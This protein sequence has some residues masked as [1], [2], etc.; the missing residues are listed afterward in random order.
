LR[1]AD[2]EVEKKS[3]GAGFVVS[4]SEG[5]VEANNIVSAT[6]P[7]QH[8]VIPPVIPQDAAVHQLHSN[9]YFNTEQLPDGAVLVVGSGSSGSRIADELLRQGRETYLS[10]GPHERPPGSYRGRDFVW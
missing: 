8:P 2:I 10:V 1:G 6:G 7:F 3:A 5:D 9:S 4:T